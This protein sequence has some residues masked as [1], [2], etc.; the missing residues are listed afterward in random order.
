MKSISDLSVDSMKSYRF[1]HIVK[2]A[3]EDYDASRAI[4]TIEDIS[5]RVSTNFVFRITLEGNEEIIAKLS[6]F[7][8]YEHFVEDHTIINALSNNLTAPFQNLLAKSL[9][10]GN[11][12]YTYRHQDSFLD[13]WV[14]FYNPIS[15]GQKLPRRLDEE[16][17]R[18]LGGQVAAFH[19]MCAKLI[20]VLPKSTKTI[21]HDIEQ[22]K[23]TLASDIGQFEYSQTS[24]K[25][26]AQCDLLLNN[27]SGLGYDALP[28]LPVFVDWNIGNFSLD[29]DFQLYS[30]W[31]YDWF[32]TSTRVM[33]FYFFS[34]VVSDLGDRTVFSYT[35]SQLSEDRFLLFLKAYHEVYPLTRD[36]VYLLKEAYRFFILNYVIKDGRYFFHELYASKLIQEA[37]EIYFPQ[38]D[39]FDADKIL[40]ALNL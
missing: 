4:V 23:V 3:W 6:Y 8:L 34:R 13:A 36:E 35:I 24:Q 29:E 9:Y 2:A 21:M 31:D 16:H 7:G 33:D 1:E 30:R 32:R 15:I 40:A 19:K 18:L 20:N 38:I 28:K 10:K 22:L 39:Q 26:L 11:Q 14:V 5:A 12:L 27:I 25:I 17:I 37:F